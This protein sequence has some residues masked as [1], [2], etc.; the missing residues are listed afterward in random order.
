MPSFSNDQA[1]FKFTFGYE[2]SLL[3]KAVMVIENFGFEILGV[4]AARKTSKTL[5]LT[6]NTKTVFCVGRGEK[7]GGKNK[8]RIQFREEI[9]ENFVLGT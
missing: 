6:F 7:K 4:V 3:N 1:G 9:N 5:F 8:G 2:L